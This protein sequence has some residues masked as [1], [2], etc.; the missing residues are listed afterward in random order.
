MIHF[1]DPSPWGVEEGQED[2][3]FKACLGYMIQFSI[4]HTH[5]YTHTLKK[6]KEPHKHHHPKK[7]LKQKL[8]NQQTKNISKVFFTSI[9]CMLSTPPH[10]L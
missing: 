3:E 6:H 9:H 8:T 4:T 1:C 2:A 10:D 5:T 7:N